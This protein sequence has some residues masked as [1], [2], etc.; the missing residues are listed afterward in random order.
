MKIKL[1]VSYD[2]TDFCGW[3]VQK[4]GVS[5]QEVLNDAIEKL[6]GEKVK[7]VGSGRTDA[8]VHAEGQVVSFSVENASV[9]P[10]NYAK[11]LN[12]FLPESVKVVSSESADEDFN[13]RY[14]AKR[15]TYEYKLYRS[16]V[17]LPLK[18]R[19]AVRV[20]E[21]VS[22]NKIAEALK[23]FEGEKDF[24]A[25][26][27]SGGG[28]KTSVRT[29]YSATVAENGKDLILRFCGNGFLYNMV[30]IMCGTAL[31]YAEGKISLL[32][33]KAMFQTKKRSL[34]GKTLPAK[35]LTLV[36]VDY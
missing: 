9:P 2:G 12:A 29:V 36:S 11:A 34:G 6:L 23:E 28:A 8:G 1:T 32:D 25:F 3:Q 5:V 19:Y 10:K 21:K 22:A 24:K 30:R 14:S 35:G 7:T 26:S 31:A 17:V 20:E 15:K 4:N 33:I 13:A 27:A 16:S 18:E